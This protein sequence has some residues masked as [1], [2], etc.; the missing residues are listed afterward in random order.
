M[1][2]FYKHFRFEPTIRSIKN[3]HKKL[4]LYQKCNIQIKSSHSSNRNITSLSK[5]SYSLGFNTNQR[6]KLEEKYIQNA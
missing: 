6:Q 1:P 2:G 4:I 5:I 3:I